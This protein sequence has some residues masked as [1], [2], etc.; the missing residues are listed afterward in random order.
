M[1]FA[2]CAGQGVD[3]QGFM[4]AIQNKPAGRQKWDVT[5]LTLFAPKCGADRTSG[6][7]SPP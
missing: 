2:V 7:K 3:F 5:N 6:P 4:S 1:F